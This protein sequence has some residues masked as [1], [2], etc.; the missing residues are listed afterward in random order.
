MPKLILGLV[1]EIATG[2]GSAAS[3][4]KQKY[5]AKSL[6]FSTPMRDILDRLF[7]PQSRENLVGL[8]ETL[9]HTFGE[10]VFA[11]AIFKE[12]QETNANLVVL[13]GIRR[14]QDMKHLK[15]L[16]HFVLVKIVADPKV[17][18]HRS[19]ERAENAGDASKNYKDFLADRHRATETTIPAVLRAATEK[20]DNNG[21]LADLFKQLDAL[22]RKYLK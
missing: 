22:V 5:G 7:I 9:R 18:F 20:I 10:D 14:T 11:H 21:E 17:C 2:K 6:R 3:Y 19:K 16:P 12:V 4:L 13:D 1:G 15:T 8:S